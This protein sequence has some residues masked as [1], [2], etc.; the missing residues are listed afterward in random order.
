MRVIGPNSFGLMVPSLKF[1]ASLAGAMARPGNVALLSQSGA[2][3]ASVLD[4]SHHE[5]VG[6]S[7]VVSIGSDRKSVV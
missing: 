7:G 2:L 4:W 5:H 3:C 6:F 1:N